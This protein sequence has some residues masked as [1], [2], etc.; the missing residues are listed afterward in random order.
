VRFKVCGLTAE[1]QVA[2]AA[3]A[4]AAYLGFV[5]FPPSPRAVTPARARDLARAAPPGVA[6]VGLV[7][8]AD[9]ALLD[10]I[11]AQVPLDLLQLHGA[12]TPARIRAI[13]ARAG[14][15]VIKAVGVGA[16][17]DLA[18]VRRAAEAADLVLL[19]ARPPRGADRPGG[20]GAPFDWGLLAGLSLPRPWFLAGGLT[21]ENVAEAV[22]RTGARQVDVSS[23][24]ESVPGV[25]D[26]AL[27]AAFARALAA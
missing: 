7:V 22:R 12:E 20:H 23:G 15:P 26:P 17:G 21:P 11:L 18:A 24:V 10:A 9:D 4:G 25:K 5:L 14:L 3:A 19:D 6:K 1:D 2:A 13:R 27:V 8:D 16:A